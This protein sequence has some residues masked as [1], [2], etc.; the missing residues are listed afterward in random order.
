MSKITRTRKVYVHVMYYIITYYCCIYI[1]RQVYNNYC[2]IT[3][4]YQY[5]LRLIETYFS[6]EEV[7][8]DKGLAPSQQT[9]QFQFSNAEPSTSGLQNGASGFNF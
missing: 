8:E 7:D 5:A 1:L 4:I 3:Q 6:E 2:C 9:D